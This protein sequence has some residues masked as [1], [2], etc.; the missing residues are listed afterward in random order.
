MSN[1]G[2][3]EAVIDRL[4]HYYNK[5]KSSQAYNLVKSIA[6]ELENTYINYISRL[7]NCLD[8]DTTTGTDL[9][10]KWGSLLNITRQTNE[11]D[12]TY[13]KR[14]KSATTSAFGGTASAI[15][16]SVAVFLGL[17]DDEAKSARCIKIYD[18]WKYEHAG[19]GMDGYCHIICVF[20]LDSA[21]RDIYY[22]GIEKD[23]IKCIDRV[24]VA[25]TVSHCMVELATYDDAAKHTYNHLGTMTY[26]QI[27]K[28]GV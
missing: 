27:R 24:K 26:D 15:Q 11:L 14:L 19:V 22:D 2:I 17:A 10:W 16:Y 9:D 25:G 1:T 4:P 5:N 8:I 21:D 23:I 28:W 6:T 13:R 7:N 20:K 18:G 12:S 3:I